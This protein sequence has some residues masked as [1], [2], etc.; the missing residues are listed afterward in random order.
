MSTEPN[1]VRTQ[2]FHKCL[3]LTGLMGVFLLHSSFSG[4]SEIWPLLILVAV[5]YFIVSFCFISVGLVIM[6]IAM[7]FS[8]Q[9]SVGAV[10]YRVVELR[11][12]DFLIPVL[13]LAWIAKNATQTRGALIMPS[14]LNKP[15]ASLLAV[16]GISTGIGFFRGDVQLLPAIFFTGKI[17]EYFIIF[18]LTLN[19]IKTEKEVR[20]FLIFVLI[21][22]AALVLYTLPQVPQTEILS[23]NRISAPFE[24]KSQPATAGGYL[25]FSFFIVFSLMLYQKSIV[26]KIALAIFSALIFIPILFTFSRTSYLMLIAG[27]I[28][29]AVLS[30]IQWIRLMLLFALLASPVIAPR[31]VKE[32]VAFTWLDGKSEGRSMGVDMSSQERI[33]S[34]QR[35]FNRLKINPVIG[36]GMSS[37]DY[38][39]NQYSR[40]LGELGIL[41]LGLW[42]FIFWRLYRIARWVFSVSDG[43]MKGL[44]LG[45]A[46]GI[47]GLLFH[48]LGSCTFY[49][50]RIMEP[51]WFMSGMIVALYL[52]KL[53]QWAFVPSAEQGA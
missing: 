34:F 19:Y 23:G 15:I 31:Q 20:F 5:G 24:V 48:A 11:V 18:F 38:V 39:D 6:A 3:V 26:R 21:T 16:M 37:W 49:I 9:I 14:P 13:M 44:A 50:V 46:A 30:N 22:M 36:L 25:T 45:Y 28:L 17:V 51:F 1:A 32:R 4:L 8:P 40:T 29:L 47:F 2:P 27:F 33:I 42:L 43:T 7:M 35:A 12:E 53:R 10:A 41:G 52:L